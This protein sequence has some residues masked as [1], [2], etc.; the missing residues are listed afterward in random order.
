MAR[1]FKIPEVLDEA[2]QEALLRQPNQRYPTGLRNYCI[3]RLILD[4]GLRASEVT[5]LRTADIDWETGRL[6]VIQGKGKRD[7]QLWVNDRTLT[8]L[9]RWQQ[10]KPESDWLFCT[11]NGGQLDDSYLRASFARYGRK[12]GIGKRVHP[13]MLRHSFGTDI[14]RTTKNLRLVQKAL[15]HSNISTTTIYTH[16]V[17]DELEQGMKGFRDRPANSSGP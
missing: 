4:A 16:I 1:P 11:L 9:K 14:F 13:H 3:M 6:K 2:E 7:R 12:A 17:D 5:H 15:G 8:D 10:R